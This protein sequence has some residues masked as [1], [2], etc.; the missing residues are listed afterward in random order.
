MENL[1]EDLFMLKNCIE[2]NDL[3]DALSLINEMIEEVKI[4]ILLNQ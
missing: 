4:Q 1:L 2:N 3:K